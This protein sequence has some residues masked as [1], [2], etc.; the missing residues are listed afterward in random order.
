MRMIIGIDPGKG[1]GIAAKVGRSIYVRK[2]DGE[3]EELSNWISG[4]KYYFEN[5][6]PIAYIEDVPK[7]VGRNI[8]SSSG[9]VLGKSYGELLGVLTAFGIR[10]NKVRPQ[11]WQK[12]VEA[13]KRDGRSDS[14]WKKHLQSIAKDL[15]PTLRVT[16]WNADALLLLEYGI[17]KEYG[18]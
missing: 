8:P 12:A 13:G 1:G 9:F 4:L 2:L 3:L 16:L 6:E 17:L 11:A 5:A 18:E 14:Q 15:F 7:F 10:P